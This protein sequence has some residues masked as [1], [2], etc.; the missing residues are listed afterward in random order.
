[1]STAHEATTARH[2][3]LRVFA[4]SL[5]TNVCVTAPS[6]KPND[7]LKASEDKATLQEEVFDVAK[8]AE[9]RLKR[10][11]FNLLPALNQTL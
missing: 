11:I 10:F 5:I 6:T 7:S 8:K 4:F 3:G 1:M 2:C 9:P